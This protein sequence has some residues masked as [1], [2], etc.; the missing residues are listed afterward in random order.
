MRRILSRPAIATLALLVL[1]LGWLGQPTARAEA[2]PADAKACVEAQKVWVLVQ[3]M[4][5]RTEGA[6]ADKF[7]NGIEALE[8]A[9]FTLQTLGAG[10]ICRINDQ[11][12]RCS[13]YNV[14]W[15]YWHKNQTA[16]GW[17]DWEF[18]NLGAPS[19][20]PKAGSIEAW[21]LVSQS[22]PAG[23]PTWTPPALDTGEPSPSPSIPAQPV[24]IPDTGLR[25]CLN[26]ALGQAADDPIT[27]EQMASLTTLSCFYKNIASLEG[28]EHLVNLTS[29]DL[30]L[31][32]ITD[33][34][35]LGD[36]AKLTTLVLDGN[37][38]A[39]VTPLTS[40]T[41]LTSLDLDGN[42]IGDVTPL[43]AM[44]ALKDLSISSQKVDKKQILAGIAG[45]APLTQLTSLDVSGN[46][47]TDLDAVKGMVGLE[48]L[49][50]Y[51]NP[52]ASLA[53]V[54]ALTSLVELNIHTTG[55]TSLE[56]LAGLTKLTKLNARSNQITSVA[57]LRT[58]LALTN[59]DLS[60]NPIADHSTL[61]ALVNLTDL[62]LESTG[63]EDLSF[64]K[65]LPQLNW[66]IIH[67]NQVGD[68]SPMA[69]RTWR[70]WGALKQQVS[71]DAQ[72]NLPVDLGLRDQ[73]GNVIVPNVLSLPDGVVPL[74]NELLFT[75]AGTYSIPFKESSSG[76]KY[77]K[78]DGV[79]TVTV[80]EAPD[81]PTPAP[82]PTGEP[83]PTPTEEPTTTPTQDPTTTPT[84]DPTASTTPPKKPIVLPDTGM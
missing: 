47:I 62:G 15:S 16:G 65:S 28:A 83:T 12:E 34:T 24:T 42:R 17:G 31:N 10:F 20:K 81:E 22:T 26:E 79:V 61:R 66:L 49:L 82:T 58:N 52:L 68:L 5:G 54:G 13:Y 51:R 77:A 55:A 75:K 36:L 72:V 21:H 14:F 57:P 18:S 32:K 76:Q 71:R 38:I 41:G 39:D 70:G 30:T 46:A 45:L 35:P 44:S 23:P 60:N 48:K 78:F 53:P 69:G 6:C 37:Q 67:S 19:Y 64:I 11:P 40:L 25:S 59:L 84:Q 27:A 9:G 29:L 56:P 2:S 63:V 50:A 8:S 80:T 73:N 33:V 4:D 7:G 3:Y 1:S 43:G 74:G